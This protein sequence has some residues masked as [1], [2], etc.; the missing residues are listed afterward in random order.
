MKK[1]RFWAIVLLVF[2]FFLLSNLQFTDWPEMFSFPY[3]VNNGFNLYKDMIHI[4]PPI[5]TL[6]L[7]AVFKFF[8]LGLG[9][10]YRYWRIR[11]L[12]FYLLVMKI[13]LFCPQ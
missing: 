11:I 9:A 7:A 1:T 10:D 3:L 12:I 4:Y 13:I 2:H 5:L 8:G 6:A